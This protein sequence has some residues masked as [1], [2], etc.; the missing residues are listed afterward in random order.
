MRSRRSRRR[1]EGGLRRRESIASTVGGNTT[2]VE[3]LRRTRARLLRASSA[4][5]PVRLF[6]EPVLSVRRQR[7][8]FGHAPRAGRRG[9][10]PCRAVAAG[11]VAA[12]GKREQCRGREAFDSARRD[13]AAVATRDH[14][15]LV[16][17][18]GQRRTG[19][20]DPHRGHRG[21]VEG[22]RTK[23]EGRRDE[24]RPATRD[25]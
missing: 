18:L 20:D 14:E 13:V 9:R 15:R 10:P 4:S 17:R 19:A 3:R 1:S 25:P 21:A 8:A 23:D 22:R 2:V 24:G 7:G 12:A 5:M 16:L 6:T 11:E